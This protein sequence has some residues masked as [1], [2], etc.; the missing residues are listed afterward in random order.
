MQRLHRLWF[1]M[2]HLR[3]GWWV[4]TGSNEEA[5]PFHQTADP[6]LVRQMLSQ[7]S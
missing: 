1:A 6:L 4:M 7:L 3:E 2:R 5:P